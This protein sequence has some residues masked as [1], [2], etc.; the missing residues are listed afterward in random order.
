[1]TLHITDN[2]I[3]TLVVILGVTASLASIWGLWQVFK[4]TSLYRFL[5][6][7]NPAEDIEW[8]A[9]TYDIDLSQGVNGY[10]DEDSK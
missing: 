9:R 2:L 6:H 8:D 3:L 4:R 5:F 7:F 1:M 10:K